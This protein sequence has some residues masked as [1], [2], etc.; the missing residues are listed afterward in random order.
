[1]GCYL[2]V[3]ETQASL[4]EELGRVTKVQVPWLNDVLLF[5][6]LSVTPNEL[7]REMIVKITHS[8]GYEVEV[9]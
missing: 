3:G 6:P 4:P 9:D 1:M 2:S 8:D 7:T 5:S